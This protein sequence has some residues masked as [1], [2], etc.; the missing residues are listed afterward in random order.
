MYLQVLKLFCVLNPMQHPGDSFVRAAKTELSDDLQGS[1]E[2]LAWGKTPS[3]GTG[4]S[5]DIIYSGK[6]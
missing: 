5:F 4:F 2:A 6:V 3:T 1:L